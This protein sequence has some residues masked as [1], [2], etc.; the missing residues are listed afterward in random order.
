MWTRRNKINKYNSYLW[1]VRRLQSLKWKVL[2][3]ITIF[4]MIYYACMQVL[5]LKRG[6]TIILNL[7]FHQY[8]IYHHFR[9][10]TNWIFPVFFL[11]YFPHFSILEIM[12]NIRCIYSS[13]FLFIL[14]KKKRK[15]VLDCKIKL[16]V[17]C[18]YV[19]KY[20]CG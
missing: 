3:F 12:F 10:N 6:F 2:F 14:F 8:C 13:R 20:M 15:P 4:L 18:V 17:L 16:K 7:K 11:F 5:E 19:C 1:E 9:R